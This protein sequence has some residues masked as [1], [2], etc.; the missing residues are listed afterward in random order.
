MAAPAIATGA[1]SPHSCYIIKPN[2]NAQTSYR[3]EI[4]KSSAKKWP[5]IFLQVA[6]TNIKIGEQLYY[7]QNSTY[8]KLK[9]AS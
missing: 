4:G 7:I 8:K 5:L 2:S 3:M 6:R 9:Q 1:D